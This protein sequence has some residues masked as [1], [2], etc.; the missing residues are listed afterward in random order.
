VSQEICERLGKENILEYRRK[1]SKE[2]MQVLMRE[3][4]K[5]E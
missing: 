3:K 4:E 2:K 1:R 5:R